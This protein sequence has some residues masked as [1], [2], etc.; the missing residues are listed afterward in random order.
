MAYTLMFYNLENLYDTID[1]PQ[2]D[3]DAYTPIGDRRWTR[4]KYLK[5]LENLSEIFSAV[6]SAHNGFPV[7]AGVSEVENLKVLQD[8]VA[9]KRMSGA[10]YKC[11]HFESNDARGV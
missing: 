10:H 8:L 9:Q 3:D 11:L 5:K 4:D 7:V 6:A 1:D 2:T